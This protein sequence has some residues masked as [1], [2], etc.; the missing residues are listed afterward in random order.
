[1]E[2]YIRLEEEKA[3]RHSKVYNWEIATYGR[4]WNDDEVHNLKFIETKFPAIVFDDTFTSQEALSREPTVSP[5]N[6]DEINFRLSFDEYDDEHY[7]IIFDKNLFS[8][9]IISI[10]DLKMDSE[11]DNDKVNMPS[12]P[13]PDL[14]ISYFDDLD[15]LKDF[16]NEFLAIVYDDALTSRLDFI[17]EPIVIP[18][19]DDEFNL[20]DET[21]F[22]K[23]DEMEQ[24]ILYFNDLFP[25]NGKLVFKNGYGVLD[26]ALP[27]R[28]H[29]HSYLRFKGLE[30]TDV[31]IMNFEERLGMLR[32]RLCLLAK[33]GGGYLRFEA[34]Y[35]TILFWSFLV[36]L[37]LERRR[38]SRLDSMH[39]GLRV[40]GKSPTRGSDCLQGR[41][42]SVGDFLGTTPSYT[43]I[44]DPM[45]R[46]CHMMIACS[47]TRRSQAPDKPRDQRGNKLLRLVP[48]EVAEDALAVYEGALAILAP[49]QRE[50]L[51]S[52]AHDFSRFTTRTITR[53]SRMMDQA[54][55][56]YTSYA[57]FQI[58]YMRRTRRRT[59]DVD[60]SAPQQPDPYSPL[61][62]L[63][64]SIL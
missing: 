54:G 20:N 62:L 9:K 57:D 42:S 32:D 12:F 15:Y 51:D 59:D 28:N 3:R 63:L 48:L 4:F 26:M 13:S 8:Y 37:D 25:F 47:I 5:L 60:T 39:T 45:L 50:V 6:D 16:N 14:M 24:K 10:D 21:S 27:Y 7:T 35:Y 49:V 36:R 18:Q 53:L 55:V 29:R 58:P 2:E 52:M 34:H 22:S 23:C 41:I 17:T 61:P 56:R 30:Y 38:L 11:N 64:I 19:H 44:K 40:R 31:D 1:M 46:L 33:L 43:S